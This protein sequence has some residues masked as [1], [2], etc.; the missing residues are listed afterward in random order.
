M[1]E[2]MA[3]AEDIIVSWDTSDTKATASTVCDISVLSPV[4]WLSLEQTKAAYQNETAVIDVY[5]AAAEASE[6]LLN[7]H[8]TF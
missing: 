1:F 7:G 2:V 4:D 8:Y 5:V 3:L 6:I